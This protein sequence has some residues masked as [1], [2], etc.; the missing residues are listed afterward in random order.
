MIGY[1]S[2]ARNMDEN[3]M[4]MSVIYGSILA[5]FTVEDFSVNRLGRVSMGDIKKRVEHFRCITKF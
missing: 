4:R 5:S 1:L 2:K 3:S